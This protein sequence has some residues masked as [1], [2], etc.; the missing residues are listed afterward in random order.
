MK[1]IDY[2][3]KQP[4]VHR[5]LGLNVDR[6]FCWRPIAYVTIRRKGLWPPSFS[7]EE[8]TTYKAW[9]NQ[10]C[11]GRVYWPNPHQGPFVYFELEH[12]CILFGL[13][14]AN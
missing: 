10:N 3:D 4:N 6:L 2:Q 9:A 12:D 1:L 7:N 8:M 11:K 13:A 14:H 5:D